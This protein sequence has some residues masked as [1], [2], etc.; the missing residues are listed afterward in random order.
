MVRELSLYGASGG[1]Q[2]MARC[3]QP[4]VTRQV[5]GLT[6]VRFKK[7]TTGSF[8]LSNSDGR[9]IEQTKPFQR[10]DKVVRFA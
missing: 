5:W 1:R 10:I 2:E 9:S 7:I 3:G 8:G 6:I 4:Q